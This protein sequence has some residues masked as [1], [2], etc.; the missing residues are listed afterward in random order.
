[1]GLASL[2][3][4]AGVASAGDFGPSLQPG[5]SA[6]LTESSAWMTGRLPGPRDEMVIKGGRSAIAE[7]VGELAF[8]LV[9]MNTGGTGYATT[10]DLAGQGS[11][12]RTSDDPSSLRF[13]SPFGLTILAEYGSQAQVTVRDGARMNIPGGITMHAN[14]SQG[15]GDITVGVANDASL[16]AGHI[17]IQKGQNDLGRRVVSLYNACSIEVV[18]HGLFGDDRDGAWVSDTQDTAI[19][20][21]DDEYAGLGTLAIAGSF[22]PDGELQ[23]KLDH[24]ATAKLVDHPLIHVTG[25][26]PWR[27]SGF[28]RITVNNTPYELGETIQVHGNP[29]VLAMASRDADGVVNDLV[30]SAPQ[31]EPE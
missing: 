27:G 5:Q 26:H 30:L 13:A 4:V 24:E 18:D 12:I 22:E 15:N 1:M 9:Y 17:A 21:F 6:A 14:A 19:L 3:C 7:D 23:V 2:A 29:L 10:L 28:K 11:V 25:D 20:A 16:S 8:G 31:A